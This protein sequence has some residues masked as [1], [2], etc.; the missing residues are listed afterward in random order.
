MSKC[1]IYLLRLLICDLEVATV[2]SLLLF[3]HP[4]YP[5]TSYHTP[6]NELLCITFHATTSSY[7]HPRRIL[8]NYLYLT[9]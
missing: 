8:Y 3:V 6:F 2:S 7:P 9:Y 1:V 4:L 5:S